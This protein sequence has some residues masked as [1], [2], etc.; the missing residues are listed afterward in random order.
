MKSRFN[1]IWRIFLVTLVV[2]FILPTVVLHKQVSGDV[3]LSD[4]PSHY[5]VSIDRIDPRTTPRPVTTLVHYD[6]YFMGG[7]RNQHMRFVEQH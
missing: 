7:F 3:Q 1:G 2:S 5:D 4:M 6:P